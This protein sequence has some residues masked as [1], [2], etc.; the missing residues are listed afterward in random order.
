M[1]KLIS[2]YKILNVLLEYVF[3]IKLTIKILKIYFIIIKYLIYYDITPK[4]DRKII[5]E[6]H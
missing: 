2:Q 5:C 6:I 1:Y 3:V 4:E